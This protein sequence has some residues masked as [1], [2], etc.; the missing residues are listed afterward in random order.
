MVIDGGDVGKV[1]GAERQALIEV[2]RFQLI[3]I[4]D[5]SVQIEMCAVVAPHAQFQ[6]VA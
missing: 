1:G 2:M 3:V 5:D 6:S 4:V